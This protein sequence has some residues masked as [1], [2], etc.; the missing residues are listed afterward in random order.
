M[1]LHAAT[2]EQ[3]RAER[4]L[5]TTVRLLEP[6]LVLLFAVVVGVIAMALLQAVYSVRPM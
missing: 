5:R 2:L 4:V 6:A 3:T 1:L